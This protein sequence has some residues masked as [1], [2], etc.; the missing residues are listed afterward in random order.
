[1]NRK[2]FGTDGIRGKANVEPMTAET[3]MRV[4][5]AAGCHFTRGDHRHLAII[6]KDTRLSNYMLEPA[7][8]SGLISMGMDVVLVGPMPTPAVAML[9]RSLRADVGVMISASHNLYE[10]NGIKLSHQ[11]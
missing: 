3:A 1:M 9:T 8:Q 6:G 10:D 4:A 7:I 2:L 5:M 11:F